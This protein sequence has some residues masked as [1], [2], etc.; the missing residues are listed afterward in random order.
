MA[1]KVPTSALED[2]AAESKASL[3]EIRKHHLA[4]ERHAERGDRLE[5][6]GDSAGA[7]EEYAQAERENEAANELADVVQAKVGPQHTVNSDGTVSMNV[8]NHDA[9]TINLYDM[10]RA[11]LVAERTGLDP[12]DVAL[13]GQEAQA[14]TADVIAEGKVDEDRLAEAEMV[15]GVV[16]AEGLEPESAT[17]AEVAAA[18]DKAALRETGVFELIEER[19]GDPEAMAPDELENAA[20]EALDAKAAEIEGAGIDELDPNHQPEP[21][22]DQR[23]PSPGTGHEPKESN[24]TF[25]A[26]LGKVDPAATGPGG[27]NSDTGD[28]PDGSP[29]GAPG[30]G[31]KLGQE[32]NAGGKAEEQLIKDLSGG[33]SGEGTGGGAGPGQPEAEPRAD[34]EPPGDTGHIGAGT[35]DLSDGTQQDVDVWEIDGEFVVTNENGEVLDVTQEVAQGLADEFG[36]VDEDQAEPPP[37]ANPYV[38]DEVI[39]ATLQHDVDARAGADIDYGDA[40]NE[41]VDES[42][43]DIRPDQVDYGGE[44]SAVVPDPD[45]VDFGDP[46]AGVIDPSPMDD[47][48]FGGGAGPG[49]ASA[50]S[51]ELNAALHEGQNSGT[52]DEGGDSSSSAAE[53]EEE[54]G[55]PAIGEQY[56]LPGANDDDP[57]QDGKEAPTPPEEDDRWADEERRDGLYPEEDSR[58]NDAELTDERLEVDDMLD[59]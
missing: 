8:I 31:G 2:S 48:E 52:A 44:H 20:L 54:A 36:D 40:A 25:D 1:E 16:R 41:L 39:Q 5:E 14:E 9:G 34:T 27:G 19:G 43:R 26:L 38:D 22:D 57:E 18:L 58:N 42:N 28:D 32:T 15:A 59:L 11:D 12:L 49:G 30:T 24:E 56:S 21:T 7:A 37:V 35:A 50:V 45:E 46:D 10:E 17:E 3:G 13:A 6:R 51:D 33:G 47:T 53:S 29:G 23:L 4:A 55:T